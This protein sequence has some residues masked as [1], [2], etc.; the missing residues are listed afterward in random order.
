M[1]D[2]D[3]KSILYYI[4]YWVRSRAPAAPIDGVSAVTKGRQWKFMG[5]IYSEL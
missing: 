5:G 4:L 1:M 2:E 3:K